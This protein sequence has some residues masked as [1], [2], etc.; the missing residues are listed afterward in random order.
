MWCVRLGL[1]SLKKNLI[2]LPYVIFLIFH[3]QVVFPYEIT[4]SKWLSG[5]TTFYIQMPGASS[6]GLSWNDA[7]K[8][9]L[10]EWTQKTVFDFKFVDEYRDPCIL[11]QLNGVAFTSDICGVAYGK[12]TLA[13]TM[14]SYR[15]EILGEPS[16]IESDI[17]INDTMNYDVYDGIP[18]LG[19]NQAADFRRM[20]LHELGHVIGLEH[21]EALRSIMAPSISEV[22]RLTTD[23]IN[24][25]RALYSG[26]D[27]CPKK[28]LMFG[29]T[30]AEL[31]K[32]DCTVSQITGGG[33]DDSFIDLYP[34][35][36]SAPTTVNFTIESQSLDAV[37][38]ISNSFLE[39]NHLDYK[40]KSGCGSELSADLQPGN[41]MLLANTFAEKIDPLCDVSGAYALFSSFETG[42]IMDLGETLS[43][44][45]SPSKEARFQ[46]GILISRSFRF[47]NT[48][49][50]DEALNVIAV[51]NVDPIHISKEGFFIVIAEV[52]T[53]ILALNSDGEFTQASTTLAELP[54]IR[55]K[56]LNAIERIDITKDFFPSSRGIEDTNVNFYVGYGLYSNV[57]EIYY[58]Q[59]PINATISK[60]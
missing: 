2:Y 13:V 5:A 31:D 10:N 59:L 18:R 34:F 58:H 56:T 45:T 22:D 28:S 20:A 23:D 26:L 36:L 3:P 54:K 25:V 41:Y 33:S 44:G 38:L 27:D 8:S 17:V 1:S 52:G 6:S 55:S 57:N 15:R 60:K 37:L 7:F 49:S 42:T 39:I 21:E 40:T 29:R 19:R 51:V 30:I 32:G 46:G 53:Q 48:R 24:A 14:R 16:I 4:G 9:A 43:T 47:T 12:N 35:S 50:S 11:D